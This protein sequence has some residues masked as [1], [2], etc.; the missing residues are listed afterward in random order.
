MH[1]S[2]DLCQ[3]DHRPML[4]MDWRLTLVAFAVVPP[5]YVLS[6]RF[7]RKVEVLAKQSAPKKVKSPP[8]FSDGDVNGGGPGLYSGKSRKKALCEG[9]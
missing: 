6:F 3:S 9:G 8:S 1:I 4:W 7:S 5:L 2:A